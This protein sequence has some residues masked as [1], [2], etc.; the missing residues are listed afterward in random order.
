VAIEKGVVKEVNSSWFGYGKYVFIVH[1]RGIASLYAHLSEINTRV[2]KKVDRGEIIGKVGSTGWAT[3]DHLH[4]EIYQNSIP[5][6]PLELLPINPREV[7]YDPIMFQIA[8]PSATPQDEVVTTASLPQSTLQT[9]P[10]QTH[11]PDPTPL[12]AVAPDVQH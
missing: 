10:L 1:D 11:M 3:G 12:T 6:D 8:S 4:L 5:L 7:A 2:N 9:L